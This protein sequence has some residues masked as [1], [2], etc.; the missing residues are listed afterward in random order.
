MGQGINI[1]DPTKRFSMGAAFNKNGS[2]IAI[3]LI[4][5]N[6]LLWVAGQLLPK[7]DID[8]YDR[9]GLH[10]WLG[11]DF[12]PYQFVTYMFLHDPSSIIH[13]LCNMFNLYMFGPIIERT[14]GRNKFL[15]YYF[16]TGVGAGIVQQLAW[17]YDLNPLTAEI[18]RIVENGMT[19]PIDRGDGVLLR[20]IGEVTNFAND[21]YN[22]R[23]TVG[24]SGAVF[25]LLLAFDMFYPNQPLYI[26]FIP[27]PIKAK[28]LV[29]GYAILELIFGV[30]SFSFDNVAHFAHL[31]GLLFGLILILYWKRKKNTG[32]IG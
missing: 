14:L 25:G 7:I 9:F 30:N 27:I 1:Q 21:V 5:I 24:A 17:A 8:I 28:Y 11:T 19:I 22:S 6:V 20:T 26:M 3:H 15:I 18:N 10:Y 2:S 16:V 13:L 23:L 31:G 12:K 4:I 29:A 32:R